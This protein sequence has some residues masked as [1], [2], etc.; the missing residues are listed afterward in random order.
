MHSS[1]RAAEI[2]SLSNQDHLNGLYAPSRRNKTRNACIKSDGEGFKLEYLKKTCTLILILLV[3][4]R[5]LQDPSAFSDAIRDGLAACAN[6]IIPSLFALMAISEILVRSGTYQLIGIPFR[7]IARR[8]FHMTDA[9]SAV[10]LISQFAGYPVG[11]AMLGSAVKSGAISITRARRMSL[12]CFGAGPAFTVSLI[13]I[14]IYGDPVAGWVI[15]GANVA[16]NLLLA[17]V[18]RNPSSEEA[19]QPCCSMP[20]SEALVT[21]TRKA[22]VNLFQICTLMLIMKVILTAA[23][24]LLPRGEVR[25]LIAACAEISQIIDVPR[26]QTLLIPMISALTAFGGICVLFQLQGLG[27]A[28]FRVK[29]FLAARICAS[30]GSYLI[31]RA[32]TPIVLRDYTA[33]VFSGSFHATKS[34]HPMLSVI[35]VLMTAMLALEWKRVERK[36]ALCK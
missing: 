24:P 2:F 18:L 32:L 22:S 25:V 14:G 3:T 20:F 6:H 1:S 21:G 7:G 12:Y 31:C 26:Y 8:L 27:G 33:P 11:L 5:I 19:N 4:V 15:Y 10:F 16:M 36:K 29:P 17:A 34:E 23:M 9:E 35:L 13:G 30:A 28:C